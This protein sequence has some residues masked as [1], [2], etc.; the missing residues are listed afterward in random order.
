[1][2][3]KVVLIKM[4]SPSVN[5]FWIRACVI[6][7]LTTHTHTRP[8][9]STR[10]VSNPF[11]RNCWTVVKTT[12]AGRSAGFVRRV[13]G[14]SV[15]KT[16]FPVFR[17]HNTRVFIVCARFQMHV[18]TYVYARG[19]TVHGRKSSVDRLLRENRRRFVFPFV[20]P[21][22][23]VRLGPAQNF[24]ITSIWSTY[25]F[26]LY[27]RIRAQITLQ[28]SPIRVWR[29]Y[30]SNRSYCCASVPEIEIKR[31]YLYIY[32]LFICTLHETENCVFWIRCFRRNKKEEKKDFFNLSFF[33]NRSM[34]K[35]R[36]RIYTHTNKN[37]LQDKTLKRNTFARRWRSSGSG[38]GW[39]NLK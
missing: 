19:R 12:F 4:P 3:I 34:K 16:V 29:R 39:T 8:F 6:R 7:R 9:F 36:T 5:K 11:V 21:L 2:R 13:S 25:W 24:P 22:F 18:Y 31:I 28:K 17:H 26:C 27:V 10:L 32:I 20:L 14:S 30:L 38:L 15:R 23:A 33:R 1:M 37:M 35:T